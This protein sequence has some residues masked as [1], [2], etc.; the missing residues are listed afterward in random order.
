[1][2]PAA[3]PLVS[4]VTPFYNTEAYLEECIQS[5]LAQ[6]YP[7][8]EYVLVNNRSTDRS[9]AIAEYYARQHPDRIRLIHND[10]LLSQ[11]RNYNQALRHISPQSKYCKIVQADDWIYPECIEKMVALAERFPSAGL[12][13]AFEMAGCGVGSTG[14]PYSK[15]FLSGRDACREFFLNDIYLFGNPTTILMRSELVRSRD[16]FYDEQLWPFED[17]AVCFDLMQSWDFAFV[18]QVLTYIRRDNESI[19]AGLRCYNFVPLFRLSMAVRY[20]S[21]FL[22]AKEHRET[23]RRLKQDYFRYL[24]S[25]LWRRMPPGF[26]NFHRQ[27]LARIGHSLGKHLILWGPLALLDY[28]GNPKSTLEAVF[29]QAADRFAA[30]GARRM[31]KRRLETESVWQEATPG[32]VD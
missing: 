2:S 27:G 1:M 16:P 14:L 30:A 31:A 6:T 8:W 3:L 5:V 28:L 23:L 19:L 26:W 17:A 22:T 29:S 12:V 7:H 10:L 25:R 4:I 20:G 15:P 13:G 32:H 21:R 11:V 9:A 18:H 24:G